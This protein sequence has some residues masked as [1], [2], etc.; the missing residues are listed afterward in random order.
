MFE[1]FTAEARH[2]LVQAQ[3]HAVRRGHGWIGCEHLLLAVADTQSP[4]GS[5]L[6]EA[7]ASPEALKEAAGAVLGSNGIDGDDTLLLATLGIDVEAV[8]RAAEATFGSDALQAA[9][10]TRRR[11]RR[12][13]PSV[14][15]SPCPQF[16]P[17]AKRC[18][19][20][21]LREALR[22]E[23][24]HIGVEH[25]TL[26]LLARDDTVAWA[27]LLHVGVIPDDLCRAVEAAYR[28]PA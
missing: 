2:L 9:R 5:L 16:T 6:R 17:K 13:R 23:D 12:G 7:G 20:L 18:L 11:R 15:C 26:A 4:A 19:E 8:T 22:L 27:V 1:R 3:E 21:S 24:R 25:I 28:S 14:R 10:G